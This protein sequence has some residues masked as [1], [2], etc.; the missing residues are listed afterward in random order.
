MMN[1]EVVKERDDKRARK[2]TFYRKMLMTGWGGG[3]SRH[4]PLLSMWRE[5][6]N[7]QM[8]ERESG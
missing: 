5:R 4:V 7:K 8:N 6:V 2:K 1:S 3:R